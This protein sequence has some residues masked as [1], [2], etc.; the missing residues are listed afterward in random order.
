MKAFRLEP[1]LNLRRI[2]NAYPCSIWIKV[3]YTLDVSPVYHR[4]RQPFTPTL[5]A[6]DTLEFQ[7]AGS[8]CGRKLEYPVRN[9][10]LHESM[11]IPHRKAPGPGIKPATLLLTYLFKDCP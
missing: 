9:H 5:T 7:C 11:E 8:D 2:L 4:E 3:G 10:A 1:D 6:A